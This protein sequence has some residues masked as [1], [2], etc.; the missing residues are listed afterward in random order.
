MGMDNIFLNRALPDP[1]NY[2]FFFLNQNTFKGGE[3]QQNKQLI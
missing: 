3:K 1:L 2:G